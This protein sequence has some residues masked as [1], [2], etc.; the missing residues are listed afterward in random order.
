MLILKR[1]LGE[2]LMIGDDVE[3]TV[4]GIKGNQVR[5][6]TTA[7]KSLKVDREEVRRRISHRREYKVPSTS[8]FAG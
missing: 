5:L 4:L 6:G 7:P 1:K 3:I 8:E 2:T